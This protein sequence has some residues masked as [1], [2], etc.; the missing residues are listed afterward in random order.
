MNQMNQM[1]QKPPATQA[2]IGLI[3]GI[4]SVILPVIAML[5]YSAQGLSVLTKGPYVV[6]AVLSLLGVGAAILGIMMSS[7]ASRALKMS[8][9]PTGMPIAGLVLSI[10]GCTWS[11]G[12]TACSVIGCF[13]AF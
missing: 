6:T 1:N 7:T 2:L 10:I 3:C 13:N 12:C 8:N 4:G 11:F 5:Y 9:Q